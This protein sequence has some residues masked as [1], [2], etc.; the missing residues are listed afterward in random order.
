MVLY[1]GERVVRGKLFVFFA[2][3]F[4]LFT[5]VHSKE[6]EQFYNSSSVYRI[7]EFGGSLYCATGGGIMKYDLSDSSFTQYINGLGFPSS[8]VSDITIDNEGNLWVGFAAHGIARVEAIETDP[9]VILYNLS[10]TS[11]ML[12]DSVTCLLSVG[13]DVYYGSTKGIAKFFDNVHTKETNLTDYLEEKPVYDIFAVG[14]SLWVGYSGGVVL[15]DRNSF[16]VVSF[17]IGATRSLC[18]YDGHVYCLSDSGIFWYG[19]GGWNQMPSPAGEALVSIASGGGNLFSISRAKVFEWSQGDWIDISGNPYTSGSLKN[20]LF[21]GYRIRTSTDIL[22]SIAVDPSGNPWV[23]GVWEGA[24]RGGYITYYNGSVWVNEAPAQLSHNDIMEMDIA[25]DGGLWIS[26]KMFGLSYRSPDSRWITYT[27]WRGDVGNNGLSY[28][29]Y[30][31]ALLLDSRGSLWCSALDYDLDRIVVGDPL[32]YADDVW[33]HYSL[34]EGTITTNRFVKAKEDPAGNR[35]FLSDDVKH[36]VGMWGINILSADG[37]H[38]LSVNPE[39]SSGMQGGNVFDCAFG[40][41]GRVYV[42]I[43]GYG[44]QVWYTGGYEWSALSD[45]SGDYW[46][47]ILG[48]DDLASTEIHAIALGPDGSVWVGT[49]SGLVRY[50]SGLIDSITVKLN[51]SDSGLIG[52]PLTILSST[53]KGTSGLQRREA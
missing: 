44:V 16:Q 42:A 37:C 35:W 53:A 20:V 21:V 23:G 30:N 17:P 50:E 12:S 31:L 25:P 24:R 52:S 49:S 47:T 9:S 14:D 39:N 32:V 13:E 7:R 15:F 45:L 48:P 8:G 22:R 43:R 2:V 19:G 11:G 10:R 4:V 3:V 6:W 46:T 1:K 5:T 29:G 27:K 40:S 38:W 34:D 33:E 28:F 36:D 26:T 51:Y 18:S 41:S